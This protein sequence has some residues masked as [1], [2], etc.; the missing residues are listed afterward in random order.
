MP[1]AGEVEGAGVVVLTEDT[2][3]AYIARVLEESEAEDFV[4]TVECSVCHI[5]CAGRLA[6][7][8]SQHI[9]CVVCLDRYAC[10][11][12][13]PDVALKHRDLRC[14]HAKLPFS[15]YQVVYI[16]TALP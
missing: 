1:H 7:C 10:D 9:M 8:P 14:P 5:V 3:D 12:R 13:I 4:S 15:L 6:C 2:I 11:P 16:S